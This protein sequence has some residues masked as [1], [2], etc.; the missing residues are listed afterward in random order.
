MGYSLVD[1]QPMPPVPVPDDFSLNDTVSFANSFVRGLLVAHRQTVVME[2]YHN[3][4]PLPAA[5]PARLI[6]V[7]ASRRPGLVLKNL[8]PREWL[9]TCVLAGALK[10]YSTARN[11]H[12][13][14]DDMEK[15]N[16]RIW[17]FPTH[18][19]GLSA[20]LVSAPRNHPQLAPLLQ[21]NRRSKRPLVTGV[22][23]L[24]RSRPPAV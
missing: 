24:H 18:F 1:P 12:E 11:A 20:A 13:V 9:H 6:L 16:D 23:F 4:Q 3:Y 8:V 15:L 22:T 19:I 21:F 2:L 5:V 14:F 17:Y 10:G 7:T